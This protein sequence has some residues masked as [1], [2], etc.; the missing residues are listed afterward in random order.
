MTARDR[1]VLMVIGMLVIVGAFWLLLIGP[2]H[3]AYS[4]ATKAA[5]TA[6]SRRDAAKEALAKA[7]VAKKNYP[8]DYSQ[9][10]Q[11]G[12]A[13]PVD[14]EV[15]SLVDQLS[16]AA[17]SNNIDFRSI[18]LAAGSGSAA[19]PPAPAATAAPATGTS[20]TSTTPTTSTATTASPGTAAPTAPATGVTAAT[21][22][23]GAVIGTAGFPT[24]PFQFTFD[25]SFFN[26]SAFLQDV[27]DFIE[28]NRQALAIRGRLL[29]IDGLGISASRKGFPDVKASISATAFLLPPEQGLTDGA[30]SAAPAAVPAAGA[31]AGTSTPP[32]ATAGASR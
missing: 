22:P 6:A 11:L 14:D 3:K 7:E 25:G 30:T 19:A 17:D 16:H 24:M 18:K 27:G 8:A 26:M 31:A 23:P 32:A 15:P 29:T 21:L 2:R 28:A 20:S 1:T 13:V 4:S 12:K 5:S 10:S 9:L